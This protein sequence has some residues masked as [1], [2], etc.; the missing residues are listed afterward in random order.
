MRVYLV[1]IKW[2]YTKRGVNIPP[3]LEFNKDCTC[4]GILLTANF[5]LFRF[6]LYLPTTL[7]PIELTKVGYKRLYTAENDA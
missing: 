2:H 3:V 6:K 4:S 5:V 1:E 7:K